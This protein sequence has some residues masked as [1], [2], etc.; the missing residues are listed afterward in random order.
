MND[1]NR[2]RAV[3]SNYF[4]WQG[5]RISAI[6]PVLVIAGL[7]LIAPTWWPFRENG[8]VV[9]FAA[10]VLGL[11]GFKLIGNYYDRTFGTVRGL[12]GLHQRREAIKWMLVYP[13]MFV[14]MIVDYW[15]RLPISLSSIVWGG[16]LLAYWWSTGRGRT[17]YLLAAGL[18]ALMSALPLTGLVEP[19]R[20]MVGVTLVTFGM[21]YIFGGVLDHLELSRILPPIPE[22][23]SDESTL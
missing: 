8:E 2:I 1:V 20:D 6:G 12:P 14:S 17:H 11:V 5:L 23:R 4:F 10:M 21:I 7:N 16:G 15:L 9:L 22:E 19:G 3:T 13:A 18:L